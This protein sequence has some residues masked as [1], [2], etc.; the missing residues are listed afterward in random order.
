MLD[1]CFDDVVHIAAAE[2]C[3]K[4]YQ[5]SVIETDRLH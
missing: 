4:L 3:V 1:D 2:L 5:A